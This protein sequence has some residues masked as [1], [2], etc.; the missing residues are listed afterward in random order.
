MSVLVSDEIL[1]VFVDVL[2]ADG[3]YPFQGFEN[4]QLRNEI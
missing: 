3:K 4:L 2:T 1:G